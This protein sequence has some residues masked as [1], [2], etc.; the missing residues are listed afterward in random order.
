MRVGQRSSGA[1]RSSRTRPKPSEP[2]PTTHVS[3]PPLPPTTAAG[4]A[5][6]VEEGAQLALTNCAFERN[7]GRDGGAVDAKVN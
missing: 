1:G 4:G 2:W 6:L 5:I 3:L 7:W